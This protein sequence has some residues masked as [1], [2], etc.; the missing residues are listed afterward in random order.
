MAVFRMLLTGTRSDWVKD[1]I[2]L[3]KVATMASLEA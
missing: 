2:D 3:L 1:A